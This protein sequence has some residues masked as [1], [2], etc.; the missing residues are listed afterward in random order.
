M[1]SDFLDGF[2]FDV[3]PCGHAQTDH[4]RL[5]LPPHD[6][7]ATAC[8]WCACEKFSAG[9]RLSP[10][11]S[12]ASSGVSTKTTAAASGISLGAAIAVVASWSVNKS[13]L[14]AVVHGFLSWI[15][16]IYFAITH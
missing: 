9:G 14:W 12:S 11:P 15:Y 6:D 7:M 5:R 2:S 4:R 13:I 16:V 10:G 3:C 8:R 1:G